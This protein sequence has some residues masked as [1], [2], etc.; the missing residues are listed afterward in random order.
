MPPTTQ[1]N[2]QPIA[3]GFFGE[4]NWLTTF[5]TPN[6]LTVQNLYKEITQGIDNQHDRL[7]ALWH[8]VA[9]LKYTKFV[10]AKMWVDGHS[11]VQQDYWAPPS[12]TAKVRVGNCATKSFLLASLLRNELPVEKVHCVLG[13]LYQPGDKG[14]HAWIELQPNGESYVMESTRADM[15]PMVPASAAD[16]YESVVYFNDEEVSFI[17]GRTVVEP[18]TAVYIEWLKDYLDWTYIA[19]GGQ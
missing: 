13:N 4:G 16:I 5:I 19:G 1:V 2:D 17:E 14:G 8:W 9:S 10:K 12:I 11:S 3:A 15:K 18:F 6:A 7:I